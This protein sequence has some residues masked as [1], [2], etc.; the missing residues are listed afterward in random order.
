MYLSPHFLTQLMRY[1]ETFL[2]LS[3]S[4]WRQLCS[5]GKRDWRREHETW[6]KALLEVVES[7][8]LSSDSDRMRS[9]R[10]MSS[11]EDSFNTNCSVRFCRDKQN[12]I[13]YTYKNIQSVAKHC[14]F[15]SL[16][17][18]KYCLGLVNNITCYKGA[19]SITK[20]LYSQTSRFSL[21]LLVYS[22]P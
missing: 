15:R 13:L 2:T 17:H 9:T 22:S 14:S 8:Q 3:R 7:R 18:Y 10:L 21:K 16:D 20:L 12:P 19:Y 6:S 5:R 11:S 4:E 1:S